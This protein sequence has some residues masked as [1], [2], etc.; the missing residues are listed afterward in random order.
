MDTSL[1]EIQKERDEIL[2][3]TSADIRN[4]AG[5]IARIKD[6]ECICVLGGEE[7][8]NREKD[9]FTDTEPLF[10]R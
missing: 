2:G 9:L 8:I 6:D 3:C 10:L 5:Y 1:F 4:L 7:E